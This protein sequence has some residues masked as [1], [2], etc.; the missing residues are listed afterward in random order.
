MCSLLL[1]CHCFQAVSADRARGYI[2][3]RTQVCKPIYII[4]S[5]AYL[6]VCIVPKYPSIRLSY[7]CNKVRLICHSLH[8][9]LDFL[10]IWLIFYKNLHVVNFIHSL[11]C[12]A[13]WV[14]MN[15]C[16]QSNI[17]HHNTIQNS[18]ITIKKMSSCS[19]FVVN[20]SPFHKSW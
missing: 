15:A 5:V 4:I 16:T 17:N 1:W 6:S 8:S 12:T 18:S 2:C 19:P 9:I 10:N 7:I 3:I 11:Q 13:L 20:S 14:L